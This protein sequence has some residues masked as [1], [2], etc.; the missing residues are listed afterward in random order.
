VTVCLVQ[1]ASSLD[2]GS[3]YEGDIDLGRELAVLHCVLRDCLAL[4]NFNEVSIFFLIFILAAQNFIHKF[5]S[6]HFYASQQP[7]IVRQQT[8]D[9]CKL[10][11]YIVHHSGG[12]SLVTIIA[13][14]SGSV[15]IRVTSSPSARG[16][17]DIFWHGPD[18]KPCYHP[19]HLMTRILK[20][21]L[22]LYCVSYV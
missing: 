5:A 19:E 21:F 6:Y 14:Y 16:P 17:S 3:D 11:I 20:G 13:V 12:V 10:V 9:F 18:H 4:N 1:D 7:V 8:S 22:I 15:A 2:D